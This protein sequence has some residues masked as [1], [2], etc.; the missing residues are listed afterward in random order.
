MMTGI[1]LT[2]ACNPIVPISTLIFHGDLKSYFSQLSEVLY[3]LHFHGGFP[4]A[5]CMWSFT[6]PPAGLA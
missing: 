6:I 5:N 3:V 4:C 1:K 2:T